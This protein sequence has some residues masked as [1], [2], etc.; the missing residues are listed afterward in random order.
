MG[1]YVIMEILLGICLR[2]QK[3][4]FAVL[5]RSQGAALFSEKTQ[6]PSGVALPVKAD[7][8]LMNMWSI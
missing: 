1:E 6:K 8:M 5:F 2:A 4:N 3:N 7:N